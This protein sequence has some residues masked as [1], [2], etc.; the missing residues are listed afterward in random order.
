MKKKENWVI[1][2]KKTKNYSSSTQP[3]LTRTLTS[4]KNSFHLV[5]LNVRRVLAF[6]V[7]VLLPNHFI[8]SLFLSL[9]LSPERERKNVF[10]A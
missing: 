8:K 5:P 3:F 1:S 7:S 2:I 9:S 10:L 6:L 4:A